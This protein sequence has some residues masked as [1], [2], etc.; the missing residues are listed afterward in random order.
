MHVVGAVAIVPLAT[1][2]AAIVRGIRAVVVDAIQVQTG[3][4]AVRQRPLTKGDVVARPFRAHRDAAFDVPVAVMACRIGAAVT[5]GAP[6][7][8]QA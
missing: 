6:D 7:V 4:I 8:I 3:T 2:P 5:H 1:D